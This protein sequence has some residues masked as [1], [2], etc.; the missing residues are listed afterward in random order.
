VNQPGIGFY[1]PNQIVPAEGERQVTYSFGESIAQGPG[2]AFGVIVVQLKAFKKI[3]LRTDFLFGNHCLVRWVWPRR[4]VATWDWYNFWRMTGL[5]SMVLAF[6][7]FL[8]IPALDGGYVM[9]LLVR[10]G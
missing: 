5:L 2:R 6:M 3:F 1:V 8:P 10:N 4:M 9:F 7:N